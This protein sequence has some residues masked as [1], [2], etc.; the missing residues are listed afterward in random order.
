MLTGEEDVVPCLRRVPGTSLCYS[1]V[2][3]HWR[4]VRTETALTPVVFTWE[5]ALYISPRSQG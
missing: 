1:F 3:M 4:A 5:F 2:G